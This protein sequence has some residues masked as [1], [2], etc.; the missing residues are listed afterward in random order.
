MFSS[1]LKTNLGISGQFILS[2]SPSFQLVSSFVGGFLDGLAGGQQ[3]GEQVVEFQ[4]SSSSSSRS[5][6]SEEPGPAADDELVHEAL[7]EQARSLP[8]EEAL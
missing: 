2:E 7:K 8:L 4:R 1:S 6:S 3:V 5:S